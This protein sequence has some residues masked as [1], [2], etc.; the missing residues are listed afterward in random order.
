MYQARWACIG[1]H[2]STT[3]NEKLAKIT[4]HM[5]EFS[6]SSL[7]YLVVKLTNQLLFFPNRGYLA[8][9]VQR[10][11]VQVKWWTSLFGTR[12]YTWARVNLCW[13][14][15]GEPWRLL[16][17]KHTNIFRYIIPKYHVVLPL[18]RETIPTLCYN[19]RAPS[20]S[21]EK[22]YAVLGHLQSNLNLI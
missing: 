15:S 18:T 17:V 6:Y 9:S 10:W 1:F 22:L 5:P 13:L 12:A 2:Y 16:V 11:G 4:P 8:F 7:R 21:H 20:C 3:N 19:I 14:V